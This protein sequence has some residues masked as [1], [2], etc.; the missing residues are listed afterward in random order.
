MLIKSGFRLVLKSFEL[1][2]LAPSVEEARVWV[3]GVNCLPLGAKHRALLSLVSSFLEGAPAEP[4]PPLCGGMYKA[5]TPTP[6]LQWLL[7]RSSATKSSG[8][9]G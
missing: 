3:R 5:N 1:E 7:R 9:S 8:S 6:C 4:D 2:V